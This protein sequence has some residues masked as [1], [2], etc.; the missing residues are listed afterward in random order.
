MPFRAQGKVPDPGQ[1]VPDPGQAVPVTADPE[2][3]ARGRRAEPRTRRCREN[4]R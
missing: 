1:G 2:R 4:I 3:V